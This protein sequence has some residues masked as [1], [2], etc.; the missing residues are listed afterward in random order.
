MVNPNQIGSIKA[1]GI[2]SP[3]I[4]V[5]EIR[6]LNVLHDDVASA[7]AESQALAFDDTLV[8]NAEN[9][10]MGGN[11]NR[12]S[13]SLPPLRSHRRGIATIVLDDLLARVAI[14]PRQANI[15]DDGALGLSKVVSLL[16][17]NHT[18]GGVGKHR[19]ELFNVGRVIRRSI[20]TAD[21][22]VCKSIG[23]AHHSFRGDNLSKCN[24]SSD[25]RSSQ[26]HV[27]K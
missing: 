12:L 19:L 7:T 1:N 5:V 22:A 26:L 23:L 21:D 10:L 18:R 20:S 17:N 8:A 27:V 16:E 13:R 6:H 2:A 11:V 9:G 24:E 14:S 3:N 25:Q 4:L 15:A